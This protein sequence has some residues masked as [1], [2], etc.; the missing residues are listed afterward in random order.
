MSM[1]VVQLAL[2]LGCAD[3]LSEKSPLTA[4]CP[5]HLEEHF[6]AATVEGS[7]VLGELPATVEWR[8]D[9]PQPDWKPLAPVDPQRKPV[10][11][12]QTADSLRLTLTET[13]QYPVGGSPSGGI[14]VP[15]PDWDR[16]DWAY[17]V[18]RARST[19]RVRSMGLG[20]NLRRDWDTRYPFINWGD[21]VEVIKDGSVQTYQLR[22]D[23]IHEEFIGS[24]WGELVIH[25]RADDVKDPV[26]IDI[27]SVSVIPK[28]AVY[29]TESVGIRTV[30]RGLAYRRALFTHPPARLKYRVRVPERGRLDFG[31]GVVRA[32]NPVTFRVSVEEGTLEPRTVFEENFDDASSWRQ[33]SVD[34]SALAGK[35]VTLILEN[36][37][38]RS[39]SVALWASPTLSGR[40]TEARPNIILYVIDGGG[41]DFTSAYGYH[42]RTTPNLER[43]VAE[44]A[45]FEN[46]YSNS[47]FTKGSTPSFMTSLHSSVLGGFGSDSDPLPEQA[48]T[49]AQL[50]HAEAYQT[51]VFASNPYCGVMSSLDRGVDALREAEIENNS[52]SSRELHDDFWAWREAYPAE[53]FWVHFQTTDVHRPWEPVAPFAGLFIDT[54]RRKRFE[55]WDR[56]VRDSVGHAS[57]MYLGQQVSGVSLREYIQAQRDQYDEAWAHNDHQI[58][59][60]IDRLKA[61]GKWSN[62]IFIL[63]ADHGHWAAGLPDLVSPVSGSRGPLFQPSMTRIPLIVV[64]P[65]RIA[66]GQRFSHPVSMI[67]VLPTILELSGLPVPE[68]AQGQSLA[69]LLL[70]KEDWTPRPVILDEF[71]RDGQKGE[72]SGLIEVVDGQWG[73]SLE[74]GRGNDA[75]NEVFFGNSLPAGLRE[76]PLLLYNLRDDPYCRQS[77]HEKRP[78][79]AEKYTRLLQSQW[80]NHRDLSQQFTRP[81]QVSLTAE[82]LKTLRALGYIE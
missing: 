16:Q 3:Q 6:E 54:E 17:V 9:K 10:K 64:W 40:R 41:A 37:A 58:G 59:R 31:L 27:L 47:S 1:A 14:Y 36:E 39:G 33:R 15:I 8:F 23:R 26:S 63:A 4:E 44:G 53:P 79:L 12:E 19:D 49:M 28:E 20:F 46:A 52:T 81:E 78:D 2:A 25:L 50:L 76:A 68:M 71:F 55:E 67:D 74:I 34:L 72:L 43:L 21:E 73:A 69:P 80:E 7:E 29:T 5:L 66:P 65:E 24:S 45:I 13:N 22:V 56:Q 32:D 11:V 51:A 30:S 57:F 48:V 61:T 60:M 70:G 77:L 75:R 18:V 38:A 42:R 62:T 35:D 82:Q